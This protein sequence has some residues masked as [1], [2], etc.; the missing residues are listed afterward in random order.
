MNEYTAYWTEEKDAIIPE[1]KEAFELCQ[2]YGLDIGID[3]DDILTADADH[4]ACISVELS[5][6]VDKLKDL[7]GKVYALADAME[8]L[9]RG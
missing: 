1:V 7:Y 8:R 5:E 6:Q 9:A 4:I 2:T 3:L